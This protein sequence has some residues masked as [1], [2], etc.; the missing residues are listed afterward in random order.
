MKLAL[1]REP[2]RPPNHGFRKID[3]PSHKQKTA[4]AM[5]VRLRA[6]ARVDQ[7]HKCEKAERPNGC[8]GSGV[9]TGLSERESDRREQQSQANNP[10]I[11]KPLQ[12]CVVRVRKIR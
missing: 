1:R 4:A 7:S 8:C 6:F 9:S 12:L 3:T 10:C 11:P 5:A 2:S